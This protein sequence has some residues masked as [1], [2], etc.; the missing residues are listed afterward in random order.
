M[1]TIIGYG[2]LGLLVL[3]VGTYLVIRVGSYAYFLTRFEFWR[4]L[5]Q[6]SRQQPRRSHP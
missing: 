2:A 6:E 4:R 5:R 3:L 1:W